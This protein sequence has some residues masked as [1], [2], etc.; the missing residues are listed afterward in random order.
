MGWG[1]AVRA[2]L[3]S[4]KGLVVQIDLVSLVLGA[5]C[6]S[7]AVMFA[8]ALGSHFISQRKKRAEEA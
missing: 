3:G 1:E 6:L 8:I 2:L 4:F 5:F 7:P